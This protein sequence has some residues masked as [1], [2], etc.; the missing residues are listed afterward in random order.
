MMTRFPV[1]ATRSTSDGDAANA[2]MSGRVFCVSVSRKSNCR[3]AES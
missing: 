1:F 2:H 3:I